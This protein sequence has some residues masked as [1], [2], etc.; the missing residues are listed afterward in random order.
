VTVFDLRAL[1]AAL[2][3]HEVEFVVV[4][5]VAV[6]AHGYLR[7]TRDLDIVPDPERAN[8]SR[9]A[10]A[11]EGMEATLPLA[12]GRAF[13]VAR[14]TPR[15][16]RGENLTLDTAHGALD[17]IQ[18]APGV[19]SFATLSADALDSELLGVPV[20]ICSLAHLRA[21]KAV[22]RRTQDKADL[23]NLPDEWQGG[24]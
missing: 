13:D 16:K 6:G 15:L 2:H 20:R 5:G 22:G 14:D 7:A 10:A 3:E 4:G 24:L 23:E 8:L 19:P 1:T 21:M 12:D 11:L 9:L 17:V 18:H